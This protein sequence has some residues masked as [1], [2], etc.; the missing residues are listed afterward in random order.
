[1]V[2][3]QVDVGLVSGSEGEG[4]RE[5]VCGLSPS[6]ALNVPLS[7][8]TSTSTDHRP[9]PRMLRGKSSSRSML[10]V[11]LLPE[12]PIGHTLPTLAVAVSSPPPLSRRQR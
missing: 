1:M 12:D 2:D 4:E 7:T 8:S 10:H 11:T 5:C 9:Q 3:V 6:A